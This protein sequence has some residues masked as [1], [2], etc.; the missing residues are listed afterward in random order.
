M[1]EEKE[2]LDELFDRLYP[3]TRSITGPG[4]RESLD[5][6]KEVIPLD[7]EHVSSGTEIFDWTIP[8]E[9]RVYDAYLVGPNGKK[10]ADIDETNLHVIN[11]SKPVDKRLSLEELKHHIYTDPESPDAIPYVTSYYDRKWGFCLSKNTFDSLPEGEYHAYIDSK[12]IDGKLSYGHCKL[13]GKSD[14]EVLIS[15]YICHPSLANNELSGPLVLCALYNRIKRWSNRHFTYRFVLAPE[16]IGSLA[17]L[18]NYSDELT[19]HLVSGA[20]LT[21]LGGYK[22]RVNYQKSR[23]GD[24]L[25]DRVVLNEKKFGDIELEVRQ[26][27]PINGSDER[28]FCSP[29]F[30]LPVGQ[31]AKTVYGE[32]DGYHNSKD[33]KEFM[34][35][36]ALIDSADHIETILKRLKYALCYKNTKPYGEPFLSKYNL[37][38]SVNAPDTRNDSTDYIQNDKRVFLNKALRVLNYCDGEREMV[39]IAEKYGY[40]IKDLDSIIDTLVE[41]KLL[42]KIGI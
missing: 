6:L 24:S 15:S 31:F 26:F 25:L 30:N 33:D 11:Y 28:Q 40:S 13:E 2:R 5:I 27:T 19:E 3:L 36:E 34:T 7:V 17:Y 29:G 9:W 4:L 39:D 35:I 22:K 18:H 32:Y 8:E 21:C 42:K 10:Y 16:T 1:K 20:V 12:F 41:K 23:M 37:Y 14:D 38:S